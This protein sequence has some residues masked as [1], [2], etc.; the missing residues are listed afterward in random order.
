MPTN[1][2]PPKKNPQTRTSSA[3]K[4]PAASS[5]TAPQ[6]AKSSAKSPARSSAKTAGKGTASRRTTAAGA[7]Q[8]QIRGGDPNRMRHQLAPY[9]F[10][11]AAIFLVVSY[12]IADSTGFVGGFLKNSMFG[13]FS[14]AAWAIPFLLVNMAIFWKRDVEAGSV[15][16][17]VTFSVLVATFASVLVHAFALHG[18]KMAETF[19]VVELFKSGCEHI[20]GGIFGG[21][22]GNLLLRGFGFA[23]TLILSCALLLLFGIFLFGMTP[24][25]FV[26]YIFTGI[27]DWKDGLGT[28]MSDAKVEREQMLAEYETRRAEQ[29]A[30]RQQQAAAAAAAHAQAVA[31]ERA[32]QMRAAQQASVKKPRRRPVNDALSEEYIPDTAP[33]QVT[34]SEV[35]EP[36]MATPIPAVELAPATYTPEPV[37]FDEAAFTEAQAEA[38]AEAAEAA[39]VVESDAPPFD[40]EESDAPEAA[41][42]DAKP[43]D[44]MKL[45]FF[46]KVKKAAPEPAPE[47]EEGINLA[48]IFAEDD[49]PPF[50]L[51]E[52]AEPGMPD[53]EA[54]VTSAE[55]DLMVE[56]SRLQ[57]EPIAPEA[58]DDDDDED[59]DEPVSEP[60]LT[61]LAR[62]YVSEAVKPE[63]PA[64]EYM[65]PPINLLK[66]NRETESV[67]LSGEIQQTANKLVETLRSFNVK[68]KIINVSR[69][70]TITRYEL[71]PEIGTKVRSIVNLVDDIALHL[72]TGGVRI[73]API[74]GKEAVGI[75][76]PNRTTSTV[77][78]RELLE[79]S[80]FKSAPSKVTTGLGMDVA[81]NPVFLDV[82]KMPHLLIAGTT[83]SGKSVCINSL[84]ISMLY[85]AR[86]DEVK[87]IM[88]DPKKVELNVYNGL[89]HLIVPVVSDPKKAA[90]SL[91]WAVTEMERRYDLIEG[92]G[93]RNLKGY[94][95]SIANDPTAEKLPQI[96]II[97]DE[98]ADLMMMARD[99]VEES[100]CRIA[101]K[102]RAAGM[103]LILGTQRPTVDVVTG[104]IKANVPSRIAFTTMSQ[105]D[106]RTIIDTVGAEKLIGRGDMLYAPIG[107]VKPTRVQGCFVSDEEVEEVTTFIK[108]NYGTRDYDQSVMETIE[109]EAQLCGNKKATVSG[110]G[111]VEANDGDPMLTPAIELAVES[112]KI[113][114]SLIQR[115]LQLGY[116]RAA[117]LIDAMEDMGI[118]GPPQGQK[119]RDVLISKTEYMEMKLRREE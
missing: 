4:K 78:I 43:Q 36:P 49:A 35:V 34:A 38:Q 104:L 72:A 30:L 93:V 90:G 71:Q 82:A 40:T 115:R 62:S 94:N 23:G 39:N 9:I 111:D 6:T 19:H 1:K 79:H 20:G 103:H 117:K 105:M 24:H 99:D 57:P 42:D 5:R 83:G 76:V 15:G 87:F 119:P 75:E 11:I 17:K 48:K 67:D 66:M 81:G 45:S 37:E 114:T 97:I 31:N 22:L 41:A 118:V 69:G 92:A 59:E 25:M 14:S 21:Y 2:T 65:F 89:P 96:V 91:H 113:S 10:V 70:P 7:K 29:L 116:G 52:P 73:E 26:V 107:S 27:R 101:Q 68:T 33:I 50:D 74:P 51:D 98:L 58:V 108:N 53:E 85:K 112:G 44:E 8:Q 28:R 55:L 77:Y 3:A 32:R 110:D 64:P 60:P 102:A 63:A 47:E 106:S 18:G 109:R 54:L 86:P 100:I 12:L 13:L 95:Q 61:E 56:R 46:R 80:A 16:Y 84:I 88:I